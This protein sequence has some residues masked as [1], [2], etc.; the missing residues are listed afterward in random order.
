MIIL[1]RIE[2]KTIVN[3]C[4]WLPF[5]LFVGH[6]G[7]TTKSHIFIIGA[8]K[9]ASATRE[10]AINIVRLGVGEGRASE[11]RVGC[12]PDQ[13]KSKAHRIGW[14]C[15][16]E[17]QISRIKTPRRNDSRTRS[18]PADSQWSPNEMQPNWLESGRGGRLII[19]HA[20]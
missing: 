4:C 19:K 6:F 16:L 7:P 11:R 17:F 13:L 10:W 9:R 3:Y 12:W 18:E 14:I 20:N 8:N 5:T 2:Y 1:D 15:E